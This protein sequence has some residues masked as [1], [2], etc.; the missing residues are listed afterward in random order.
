MGSAT[1]MM[2][3]EVLRIDKQAMM[4]ALHREHKLSDLFVAYLLARNIR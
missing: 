2:D 3:C 1:A 4:M